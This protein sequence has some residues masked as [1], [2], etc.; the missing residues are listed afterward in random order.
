MPAFAQ[1][2]EMHVG[3][4]TVNVRTPFLTRRITSCFDFSNNLSMVSSQKKTRVLLASN[5][6]N[7]DMISA[8]ENAYAT[9]L[10]R[11]N[12]DLTSVMFFGVGNSAI[13]DMIFLVGPYPLGEI[14]NPAK[15]AVSSA[16]TNLSLL[17]TIPLSEHTFM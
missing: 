12:H 4:P 14:V 10:T 5:S 17:K 1:S 15:S 6:L 2:V 8:C 16:N 13:A 9:W 7:G 11:P 3:R